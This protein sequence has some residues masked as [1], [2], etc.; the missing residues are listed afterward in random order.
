MPQL[1]GRE[2]EL[3]LVEAFMAGD[4][5]A[6]L[7]VL[8]EPGI[9]KTTLWSEAVSLARSAGAL[10]LV[11]RPAESEARLSFAGLTD[12]LSE[13]GTDVLS[14]LP[15]PQRAALDVALLRSEAGR[16]PERRLVGTAVLSLLRE[17]ALERDVVL[18][19]DDVQWLDGPSAAALA[20][21]FRRLAGER[22]RA[23]VSVRSEDAERSWVG[24][25]GR[26][27]AI[28]PLELGPLSLAALHR[29]VVDGLGHSF[30]RP[31]L[32]RIAQASGGNPL[33]ALEIARLLDREDAQRDAPLPVPDGLNALVT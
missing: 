19:L 5:G 16:P 6:A 25:L 12:L 17:L 30:P 20:F 14:A 32:V 18:A 28:Q 26:D 24:S 10:V 13:V 7:A 8:G 1:V 31:T 9:G 23:I 27:V 2:T 4:R 3:A 21:A 29:V 33:Y 15:S 22:V 11:A